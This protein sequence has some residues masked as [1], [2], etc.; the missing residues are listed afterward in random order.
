VEPRETIR[1]KAILVK[2][3]ISLTHPAS[4]KTKISFVNRIKPGK[5]HTAASSRVTESFIQTPIKT[6]HSASIP[7]I[8][9]KPSGASISH[10]GRQAELGAE[11]LNGLIRLISSHRSYPRASVLLEEQGMVRVKMILDHSGTLVKSVLVAS[12]GFSRLDQAALET[13]R[14]IGRFPVP[15]RFQGELSVLVPIEYRLTP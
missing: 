12:S 4:K 6:G 11:Y 13:L 15:D 2:K 5:P 7:V 1:A 9:P 14:K 8:A 3:R 10:S